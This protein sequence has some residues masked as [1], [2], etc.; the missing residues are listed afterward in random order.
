MAAEPILDPNIQVRPCRE[1][2]K[3]SAHTPLSPNME[4]R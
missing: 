1:E 2:S 4:G 3:A